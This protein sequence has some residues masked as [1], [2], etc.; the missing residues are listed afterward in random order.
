MEEAKGF[1]I[2]WAQKLGRLRRRDAFGIPPQTIQS[3]AIEIFD[4]QPSW[5]TLDSGGVLNAAR[6]ASRT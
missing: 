2:F 4:I 5:V 1:R 3:L 6:P